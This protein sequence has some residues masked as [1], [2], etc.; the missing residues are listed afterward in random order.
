M[1]AFAV[2]DRRARAVV[3]GVEQHAALQRAAAMLAFVVLALGVVALQNYHFADRRNYRDDE[4][5]TVHAGLTM[6]PS[7]VVQ[8]MSI[9]IH[10]PL[11]R[12][13]AAVWVSLFGPDE[14]VT[15]FQSSLYVLV[16]LAFF[17]RLLA[18]LFGRRTAL[19]TT[20]LLG[21]HA[22]FVFYTHE[23][24]PYAALLMWVLALHFFFLR[25][26]RRPGFAYAAL[27]VL[28]C[29]GALYTHFFALYAIAGQVAAFLLLVRWNPGLYL[30]AFGLWLAAGLSFLGWLPSFLHS[31]LVSQPGGI[32]YGIPLD[33]PG[34]PG[35][36]YDSLQLRPYSIGALLTGVGLVWPLRLRRADAHF[37]VAGWGK[38][39]FIIGAVVAFVL[40]LLTE[41]YVTNVLTQR[42]LIILLP[43]ITLTAALG[44]RALPWQASLLVLPLILN[45]ALRDFVNYQSNEPYREVLAFVR[46]TYEDHDPVVIS[47]DRGTGAYFTFAYT[48]MDRLPGRIDQRDMLYLTLGGPDINLPDPP[49][50]HVTDASPGALALFASLTDG[51]DQLFWISSTDE[52]P[53]VQTY[54]DALHGA[55][56][57][58]TRS[59]HYGDYSVEAYTRS[60]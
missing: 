1:T 51:E 49:L 5:R 26:L 48:L 44:L 33:D 60:E 9:D 25:W 7:E 35:L 42:N 56:F 20:F 58:L 24:R 18:D 21:T 41:A 2:L 37:R 3:S 8:W 46:D 40:V 15:R 55:G 17:Y 39:Y 31:Y 22:L 13:S 4:I 32:G 50:H 27:Y 19:L 12:V 34:S 11:W 57:T 30:R 16:G 47:V 45:P 29:A 54:R 52:A 23:L 14:G 28:S 10:P 6:T 43:A 36:I 59:E 38:W 53:Y